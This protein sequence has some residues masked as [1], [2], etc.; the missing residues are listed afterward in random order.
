MASTRTITISYEL[1]SPPE[2][3]SNSL[4]TSKTHSFPI[5]SSN[6]SDLPGYYAALRETLA[7]AKD[8]VGD[9]LTRWRDA[10]GKAELSKEPK[11]PKKEEEEEEENG[12][13]E[14]A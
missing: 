11:P 10:T 13:D 14:E 2:T 7:S 6:T 5:A 9:E 1:H 8:T 3:P 4:S 12:D